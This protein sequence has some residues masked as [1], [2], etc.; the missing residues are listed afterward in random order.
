M[1]PDYT[2]AYFVDTLPPTMLRRVTLFEGSDNP[3]LAWFYQMPDQSAQRFNVFRLDLDL[4]AA[5]RG[6]GT[7]VHTLPLNIA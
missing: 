1:S 5:L 4:F 2:I 3:E 7:N 6:C